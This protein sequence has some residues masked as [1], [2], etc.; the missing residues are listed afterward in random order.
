M[1]PGGR[2]RVKHIDRLNAS[3]TK[4]V[5]LPI[6]FCEAVFVTR[7]RRSFAVDRLPGWHGLL[8]QDI[9]VEGTGSQARPRLEVNQGAV[10]AEGLFRF[11]QLPQHFQ[12]LAPRALC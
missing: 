9:F 1:C 3:A 5:K 11:R 6:D 10:M 12:F 4:K 2:R 7:M 8:F